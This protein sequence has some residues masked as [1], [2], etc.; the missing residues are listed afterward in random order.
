M[1]HRLKSTR[2]D[3]PGPITLIHTIRPSIM[4]PKL[5]AIA[6][7]TR[8]GSLNRSILEL[9][10]EGARSTGATVTVIEL[11]DYPLPIYSAEEEQKNGLPPQAV[12]LQKHFADA[13]GLLLACPE[14]N[15]FFP[16]LVKNTFDWIS[17]PR[18]DGSGGTAVLQGRVA[19][20][21]SASPGAL[22][23]IR[24][25]PMVRLQLENLGMMVVARQVGVG[26]AHTI[27]REGK[28][29]DEK[30]ATLLRL[31]G[32]DVATVCAKLMHT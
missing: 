2:A 29:T 25:L 10:I 6:G 3:V 19:G 12:A 5:L 20:V 15:G 16:A 21:M 18:P 17:R 31:I 7:S 26:S 27:I 4:S 1:S 28:V 11:K 8:E 13:H 30:T 9:A 14:Y 24:S 22:G 23:G 32:A